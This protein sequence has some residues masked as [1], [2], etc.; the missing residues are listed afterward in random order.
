MNKNLS[1]SRAAVMLGVHPST[2]RRWEAEGRI[3][4]ARING[5]GDRRFSVED[6][7]ALAGGDA[8]QESGVRAAAYVRVRAGATR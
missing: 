5:R 1:V 6:L 8:A 7:Q 4:A 3:R 2:L